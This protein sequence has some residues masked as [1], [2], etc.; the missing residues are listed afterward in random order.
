[1]ASGEESFDGREVDDD[2]I[3]EKSGDKKKSIAIIAGSAIAGAFIGDLFSTTDHDVTSQIFYTR[4]DGS[5]FMNTWRVHRED[6]GGIFDLL[7]KSRDGSYQ[8]GG[9]GYG[10]ED[11]R[12][13][14]ETTE[15]TYTGAIR[16]GHVISDIATYQ[17][18][19]TLIGA[20]AGGG[21][22]FGADYIMKRRREKK[23]SEAPKE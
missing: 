4:P 16:T 17:G 19:T 18:E 8:V 3:A 5:S 13:F 20:A 1:M 15:V 6:D 23:A 12:K 22:G 11:Y 21:A 2:P 10:I 9:D 7:S 14:V